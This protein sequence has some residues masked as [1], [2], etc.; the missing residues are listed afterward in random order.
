MPSLNALQKRECGALKLETKSQACHEAYFKALEQELLPHFAVCIHDI[1][2]IDRN[3]AK[4]QAM[5]Q[6][7]LIQLDERGEPT[8]IWDGK[9]YGSA[10]QV[11]MQAFGYK[12]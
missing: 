4:Y 1:M 9:T 5:L 11:L 7:P 12:L 2:E 10:I 6:E 3:D 8:G